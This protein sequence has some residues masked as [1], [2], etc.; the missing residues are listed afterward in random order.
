MQWSSEVDHCERLLVLEENCSLACYVGKEYI[1]DTIRLW[2]QFSYET[3]RTCQSMWSCIRDK[4][5]L[6]LKSSIAYL[7]STYATTRPYWQFTSQKLSYLKVRLSLQK[8]R[9]SK[10]ESGCRVDFNRLHILEWTKL[11]IVYLP[12]FL[13]PC[14]LASF[15]KQHEFHQYHVYASLSKVFWMLTDAEWMEEIRLMFYNHAV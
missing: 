15:K 13:Q 6:L 10:N 14:Y 1:I 4:N 7:T 8:K 9:H 2:S 12:L 11:N 5:L 3:L